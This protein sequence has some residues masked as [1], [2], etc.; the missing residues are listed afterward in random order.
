MKKIYIAI[1]LMFYCANFAL[2]LDS[3]YVMP[4]AKQAG[5][6]TTTGLMTGFII[7]NDLLFETGFETEIKNISKYGLMP[8][9]IDF[10]FLVT[11]KI[12]NIL[13]I[14]QHS[15][16]HLIENEWKYTDNFMMGKPRNKFYIEF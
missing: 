15:C 14:L 12:N 9:T 13:I 11:K 8:N 16:F 1:I 5:T 2:C 10:Y 3:T 6:I 7:T 4:Y